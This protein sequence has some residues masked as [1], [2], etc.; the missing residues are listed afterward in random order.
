MTMASLSSPYQAII[1]FDTIRNSRPL[2]ALDMAAYALTVRKDRHGRGRGNVQ[3]EVAL[4]EESDCNQ[5][6]RLG[7]EQDMQ[8]VDRGCHLSSVPYSYPCL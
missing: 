6:W 8:R 1:T 7:K 2:S 5:Y 3:T 4:A